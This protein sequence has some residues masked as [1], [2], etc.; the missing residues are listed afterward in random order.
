MRNRDGQ[1]SNDNTRFSFILS[2]NNKF[3][4]CFLL[5]SY[6]YIYIDLQSVCSCPVCAARDRV[7]QSQFLKRNGIHL[8]NCPGARTGGE[9]IYNPLYNRIMHSILLSPSPHNHHHAILL[10][11]Q[12]LTT[13]NYSHFLLLRLHDS[14]ALSVVSANLPLNAM[15]DGRFLLV[16]LVLPNISRHRSAPGAPIPWGTF[17]GCVPGSSGSVASPRD[18]TWDTLRAARTVPGLH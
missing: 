14:P 13:P 8:H 15:N 2:Q 11:P 12:T 4:L 18:C 9:L 5:Y 10:P 1:W 7:R 3:A 17:F 16:L 6:T